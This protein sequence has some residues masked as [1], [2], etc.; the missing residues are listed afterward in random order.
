MESII[1]QLIDQYHAADTESSKQAIKDEL[2]FQHYHLSAEQRASVW[3]AMQPFFDE[4]EQEMIEKDPLARQTYEMF[5][6]FK[7]SKV[8]V[9]H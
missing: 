8:V 6:R 4:I 1:L 3:M 2:F 5:E 9:G 7:A